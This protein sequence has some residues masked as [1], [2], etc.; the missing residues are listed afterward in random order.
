MSSPPRKRPVLTS[1]WLDAD[2]YTYEA[3][4]TAGAASITAALQ[5]RTSE[6][7]M[8][9]ASDDPDA[10]RPCHTSGGVPRE[11]R[12]ARTDSSLPESS[13]SSSCSYV[14]FLIPRESMPRKRPRGHA[15][16]N[17]C[18]EEAAGSPKSRDDGKLPSS[19]PLSSSS[20]S[21][22]AALKDDASTSTAD[23]TQGLLWTGDADARLDVLEEV[24]LCSVVPRLS[25][26][27][28]VDQLVQQ[29]VPCTAFIKRRSRHSNDAVTHP[30]DASDAVDNVCCCSLPTGCLAQLRR[31][32][33]QHW[34]TLRCEARAWQRLRAP[35]KRGAADNLQAESSEKESRLHAARVPC[36]YVSAWLPPV[37]AYMKSTTHATRPADDDDVLGSDSTGSVAEATVSHADGGRSPATPA[38]HV[39]LLDDSGADEDNAGHLCLSFAAAQARYERQRRQVAVS[40]RQRRRSSDV[41]RAVGVAENSSGGGALNAEAKGET[42]GIAAAAS[43]F[44][45]STTAYFNAPATSDFFTGLLPHSDPALVPSHESVSNLNSAAVHSAV[46]VYPPPLSSPLSAPSFAH[47]DGCARPAGA[48]VEWASGVVSYTADTEGLMHE[49]QARA[50]RFFSLPPPRPVFP[51]SSSRPSAHDVSPSQ[52]ITGEEP[53]KQQ[54]YPQGRCPTSTTTAAEVEVDEDDDEVGAEDRSTLRGAVLAQ[55]QRLQRRDEAVTASCHGGD[56]RLRVHDGPLISGDNA[57]KSSDVRT[58]SL[59]TRVRG[60]TSPSSVHQ[61]SCRVTRLAAPVPCQCHHCSP[62][63]LQFAQVPSMN[64]SVLLRYLD[65]LHRTALPSL[66]NPYPPPRRPRVS[67]AAAEEARCQAAA[68][69]TA[70]TTAAARGEKGGGVSSP[71]A[72]PNS[73]G[74]DR[75][76]HHRESQR[77]PVDPVDLVFP[78]LQRWFT[79]VQKADVMTCGFQDQQRKNQRQSSKRRT[80]MARSSAH[81]HHSSPS[82]PTQQEDLRSPRHSFV[83]GTRCSGSNSEEDEEEN[84]CV[85][86]GAA[87][88]DSPPRSPL[89]AATDACVTSLGWLDDAVLDEAVVVGVVPRGQPH[90][91]RLVAPSC[92]FIVALV[93]RL[94]EACEV[95]FRVLTHISLPS[96]F[97]VQTGRLSS[98]TTEPCAFRA[99]NTSHDE[100]CE[101]ADMCEA[102]E[103]WQAWL[104]SVYVSCMWDTLRDMLNVREWSMAMQEAEKLPFLPSPASLSCICDDKDNDRSRGQ[105][106]IARDAPRHRVAMTE[107]APT[108]LSPPPPL[109]SCCVLSSTVPPS[110]PAASFFIDVGEPQRTMREIYDSVRAAAVA[111]TTACLCAAEDVTARVL[112]TALTPLLHR[113]IHVMYELL[114]HFASKSL[115]ASHRAQCES[116][117]HWYATT[118]SPGAVLRLLQRSRRFHAALARCYPQYPLPPLPE[119]CHVA[120]TASRSSDAAG[121]RARQTP[122]AREFP[123]CPLA[124]AGASPSPPKTCA[125]DEKESNGTANKPAAVVVVTSITKRRR[126]EGRV[127]TSD[128]VLR[129]PPLHRNDGGDAD[130]TQGDRE[131]SCSEAGLHPPFVPLAPTAVTAVAASADES[132]ASAASTQTSWS[133]VPPSASPSSPMAGTATSPAAR[134]SNPPSSTHDLSS[135]AAAASTPTSAAS[136]TSLTYV[137]EVAL[138]D[139]RYLQRFAWWTHRTHH[140]SNSSSNTTTHC[141]LSASP[142]EGSGTAV[143]AT[144]GHSQRHVMSIPGDYV[145]VLPV[146]E[147]DAGIRAVLRSMSQKGRTLDLWEMSQHIQAHRATPYVYH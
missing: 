69:A 47:R 32:A 14:R 46:G 15:S 64:S 114:H 55:L 2:Q 143:G 24:E 144:H 17:G 134:V 132:A 59:P 82:P 79:Q 61:Q 112:L 60:Q 121:E 1:V 147:Q 66:Q 42:A 40:Q 12:D 16:H 36:Q 72:S 99:V 70:T 116:Y 96:D 75:H 29:V 86:D 117:Q 13:A 101:E 18:K 68:T 57:G 54:A 131:E 26:T 111:H 41:H 100:A 67:E 129:P 22:T 25:R 50:Q 7:S 6:P 63:Q 113:R 104:E 139:P 122:A 127:E 30:A 27:F 71:P 9:R 43:Q 92:A 78:S 85:E 23:N 49:Q 90:Q 84:G 37:P 74:N 124:S 35:E 146:Q 21:F 142:A 97:A 133:P 28:G 115:Y 3:L 136:T 141:G 123:A 145:R 83:N 105:P 128:D 11:G 108:P 20:L 10:P 120:H 118:P 130:A 62:L 88:L 95:A 93:Q 137:P 45:S 4:C 98:P 58:S 33:D 110:S 73:N 125:V 8:A 89:A 34:M 80:K 135:T 91:L 109:N 48:V 31:A 94:E 51:A 5:R 126:T 53:K 103:R 39:S 87:T 65:L 140:S 138:L 102:G 107:A 106:T 38:S 76:R 52:A 56:L 81:K 44:W 19:S 77:G 119:M